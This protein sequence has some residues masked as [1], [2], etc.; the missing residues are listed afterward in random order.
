MRRNRDHLE[1]SLIFWWI[2][3]IYFLSMHFNV[4][5]F[6]ESTRSESFDLYPT[7]PRLI[8]TEP[9]T[10]HIRPKALVGELGRENGGTPFNA[11]NKSTLIEMPFNGTL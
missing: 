7:E 9:E 8:T 2:L 11:F 3:N 6:Y 5:D 1:N 4:D 10:L